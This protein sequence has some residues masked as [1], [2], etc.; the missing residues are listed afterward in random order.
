MADKPTFDKLWQYVQ[1]HN[2]SHGLMNWHLGS[3]GDTVGANSATDGDEDIGFALVLADK[4]W[5]GYTS[6]TKEY[7]TKM[8]AADFAT[9]GTVRGGDEFAN[10][11]PSY[12]A[13]AFYRTFAA[14]SGDK[15]WTTILDKSYQTLKSTADGTTGLVPDW[16]G[17]D[18]YGYDAARTPFRVA[19][20]ACWNGEA[21]A[22]EF[23]TKIA[24]FFAKLGAAA[25]KDGFKLN[26]SVTGQ[27]N[28]ATFVGPA[29]ASGM[30]GH[31]STLVNDVYA[32]VSAT[33]TSGGDSYYNTSWAFF[34]TLMMT[35]NFIDFTNP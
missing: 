16:Q 18:S 24:A 31:Q 2:D 34:T 13:P 12:L 3:G 27:V 1:A 8:A 19:L 4:Q 30:A 14:Y 6:T 29:G 20:D 23:S 32:A 7:L 28:N 11:N 26:G 22:I 25:I 21:R 35:G 17:G 33:A 5:G 15:R 10:V 9:D